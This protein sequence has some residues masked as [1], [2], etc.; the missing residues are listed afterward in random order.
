MI[1]DDRGNFLIPSRSFSKDLTDLCKIE[2]AHFLRLRRTFSRSRFRFR[3]ALFSQ[4]HFSISC[5][6]LKNLNLYSLKTKLKALFR[7]RDTLF[8][9]PQV[10]SSTP[11]STDQEKTPLKTKIN[12]L[13]PIKRLKNTPTLPLPL[14]LHSTAHPTSHP[15]LNKILSKPFYNKI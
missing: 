4:S 12:T 9:K 8:T 1:F 2:R 11:T 14:Y 7:S 6:P 3:Q 10:I 15:L 13:T 5:Q